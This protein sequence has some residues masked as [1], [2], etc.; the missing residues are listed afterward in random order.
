MKPMSLILEVTQRCNLRCGH[1]LRGEPRNVDMT[2]KTALKAIRWL[3]SGRV[4]FILGFSGGEPLLNLKMLGKLIQ[5]AE[6]EQFRWEGFWM[7]TNGT[8]MTPEVVELLERY[9][10]L[11]LSRNPNASCVGISDG[12]WHRAARRAAGI[13]LPERPVG[14]RIYFFQGGTP[15]SALIAEGR[16]GGRDY[17][18]P[19]KEPRIVYITAD[20]KVLPSAETAYD[21]QIREQARSLNEW[22]RVTEHKF[23]A[24]RMGKA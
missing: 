13:E 10:A 5:V 3:R 7:T 21:N 2:L 20:G 9:A 16:L 12:K 23:N 14:D 8:L 17:R 4:R 15:D 22:L 19:R 6:K 11:S 18:G 24:E 1:C